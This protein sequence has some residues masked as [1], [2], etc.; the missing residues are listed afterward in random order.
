MIPRRLIL[1]WVLGSLLIA[2]LFTLTR[3]RQGDAPVYRTAALRWL[4]GEQIYRPSDSAAFTYPPFF[5]FAYIPFALIPQ[6]YDRTAWCF[7]NLLLLGYI[8]WSLYSLLGPVI[9]QAASNRKA[10]GTP[11]EGPA[12]VAVWPAYLLIGLLSI[13]FLISPIEYQG[14]DLI[15][16]A[17]FVTG[18]SAMAS[19]RL[20][21]SGLWIGLA[22]ACKATPL[23][24]VVDFFWQR[25]WRA[26]AVCVLT[27]M[28]ASALPDLLVANPDRPLWLQSWYDKFLSHLDAASAPQADGAWNSWNMLNQSLSGTLYRLG[29]HV[30]DASEFRWNAAIIALS[31]RML[32]LVTLAAKLLVLALV[33]Y[34]VWPSHY[35][36]STRAKEYLVAIQGAAV[37][38]G[39]LL[40][41]PMTSKQH[42]CVLVVPVFVLVIEWLYYGRKPV[43]G[44]AL[45]SLLVLGTL[46]GKDL[47]GASAHKQLGAY[48]SLTW[49]T[50][51]CLVAICA[52]ARGAGQR[53]RAERSTRTESTNRIDAA[54]S[55]DSR[56]SDAVRQRA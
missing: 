33:S 36:H 49:M 47:V 23:L 44:V 31:P 21:R 22:A 50:F 3:D 35:R 28:A 2:P 56:R 55:N 54:H 51:L 40:L 9:V 17:L 11:N 41:S 42:F 30:E 45:A 5:V 39:M 53:E 18:L 26:L 46:A 10:T 20:A 6:P 19:Q 34:A 16:F 32:G 12:K 25:R 1:G 7:F 38:L 24:M 52:V 14:H 13:R 29:T 8:L 43:V 37:L 4:E 27:V 48:G 15:V